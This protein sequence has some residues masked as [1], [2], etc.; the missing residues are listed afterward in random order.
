MLP[1]RGMSPGKLK[2]MMKQMGIDIAELE[3]VEKVIIYT[4]Q[5][6]LI[7]ENPS[8]TIMKA[9]GV[10]TFQISGPYV[11][12]EKK[13]PVKEE[14]VQLVMEQTGVDEEEARRVLEESEGDL[15]EAILKLSQE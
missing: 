9:K 8:V 3:D 1:M 15:A 4:K 5:K 14:D 7:F 12:K 6:D 10:E 13:P 2:Q 11:E